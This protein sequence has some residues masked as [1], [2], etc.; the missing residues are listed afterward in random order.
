MKEGIAEKG[1]EYHKECPYC[2]AGFE[3]SRL[4]QVYCSHRCKYTSNNRKRKALNHHHR[5]IN[6]ILARNWA[7]LERVRKQ[8]GNKTA[9]LKREDLE[10]RGYNFN[11]HTHH[12]ALPKDRI[13]YMQYN[14]GLAYMG[15]GSCELYIEKGGDHAGG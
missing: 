4:N 10:A 2:G 14:L 7:L 8:T 5:R 1:L 11:Y 13:V 15:E 6:A 12:I 3:A 9:R